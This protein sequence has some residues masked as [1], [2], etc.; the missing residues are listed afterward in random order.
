M[1]ILGLKGTT[2]LKLPILA[3]LA[4]GYLTGHQSTNAREK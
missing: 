1:L 2:L 3:H 4:L